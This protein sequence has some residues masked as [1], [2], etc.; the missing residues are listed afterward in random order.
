MPPQTAFSFSPVSFNLAANP[1][2]IGT[3][4]LCGA[5]AGIGV[6]IAS[7]ETLLS[8]RNYARGGI[9]DGQLLAQHT[10]LEHSALARRLL[11]WLFTGAALYVLVGLRLTCGITL[12]IPNI[13][14]WTRAVAAAVAFFSGGTLMW[15]NRY[16]SDGGD[17]MIA[18]V[19][20]GVAVG[21]F[22][23][24]SELTQTAAIA[25]IAVQAC[26][27]YFVAGIAKSLSPFWR[28]GAVMVAIMDSETWGS[29]RL[30]SWLVRSRLWSSLA[31]W[32]V[33][34]AECA[35]PAVVFAPSWLTV[36]ILSWGILFHTFC[37]LAMGF[38]IFF[39]AFMAAYP[40]ILY[41]RALMSSI[42]P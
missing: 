15:R 24:S 20:A 7:L 9:F 19:L 23:P 14:V 32:T 39:W 38:N 26:L 27:A 10:V 28:S 37:A 1:E 8:W 17:Q 29:Y 36:V 30:G 2:A 21:S 25:F 41:I 6:T 11:G 5:I 4:A 33:I 13:S 35:F 42:H 16:G 18:I 34:V 12:L 3:L 22:F 40:A 31:S